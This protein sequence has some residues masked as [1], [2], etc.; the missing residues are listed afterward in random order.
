MPSSLAFFTKKAPSAAF[1]RRWSKL[2][3]RIATRKAFL[4]PAWP[5][6]AVVIPRVV[7]PSALVVTRK[8]RRD[9]SDCPAALCAC[10]VSLDH[11]GR[12]L[13]R[14]SEENTMNPLR[15]QLPFI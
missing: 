14:A 9:T 11:Q 5:H 3:S 1:Q 2:G 6:A 10:D 7:A 12:S 8:S 15:P 13:G 4:G